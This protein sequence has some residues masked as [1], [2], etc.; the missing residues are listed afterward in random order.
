MKVKIGKLNDEFMYLTEFNKKKYAIN[1]VIENETVEVDFKDNQVKLLK[2]ID[3]SPNRIKPKCPYYLECGGCMLQHMK[4]DYQLDQ[5]QK[6]I[7]RLFR[8]INVLTPISKIKAKNEFN[9][10]NKCQLTFGFNNKKQPT[11]GFYKEYSHELIPIDQCLIEDE[12]GTKIK[13][14][15][16]DL[17]NKFHYSYFNEKTAQGTIKHIM[18]KTT[19]LNEAMVIIV[20]NDL[21]LKGSNAFV[22]AIVKRCPNVKTII[23]SIHQK[24]NTH[25]LGETSKILYGK[26]FITDSL[27]GFKF[28]ISAKSFYQ[29]NRFITADLYQEVV[30]CIKNDHFDTIID[31]YSGTSTISVVVSPYAKKIISVELEKDATKN[32]LDNIKINNVKNITVINDDAT[33]FINN[34]VRKKERIDC[35]IMDPPRSGSTESFINCLKE[36]K[37]KKIVYISCGPDTQVRDIKP[38]LKDYQVTLIQPFDLF[39]N[40]MHVESVCCLVSRS[41]L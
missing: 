18:V 25:V 28:Q 24:N 30:N 12:L 37:P 33:R 35:V 40:T 29:I 15:V 38:L 39:P 3:P 10:R 31:A 16:V 27:L 34:I 20:T 14:E 9:Y 11:V 21:Q 23:Q 17:I 32:A 22:D 2:I 5:K 1:K 13:K 26:G 7:E 4:Y 19:T 8:G 41:Q 36:L 6:I